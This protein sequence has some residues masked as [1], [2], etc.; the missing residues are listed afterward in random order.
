MPKLR[1]LAPL[2]LL[3]ALLAGCGGQPEDLIDLASLES[4]DVGLFEVM[5][6][7]RTG[8]SGRS[9]RALHFRE[10]YGLTV[11]AVWR[12]GRAYSIELRDMVLEFGDALLV[13]GPWKKL[14]VLGREPDF[15][16]LTETA[17]EV[18]REE[19]AGIALGIL[20]LFFALANDTWVP[21]RIPTW[22]WRPPSACCTRSPM[23][24]MPHERC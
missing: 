23:C 5:L 21:V 10:K 24:S 11:L 2:V 16:V 14:N 9:L 7:P 13:Y 22:P 20:C 8:L 18:P 12:K 3:A 6:S 17:Q 1:L 4:A 19:K 15:L